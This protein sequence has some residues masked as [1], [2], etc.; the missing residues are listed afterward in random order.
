MDDVASSG[1]ETLDELLGGLFWGDN[2]VWEVAGA[3]AGDAFYASA[4][5]VAGYD[6]RIAIRLTTPSGR[7]RASR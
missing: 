2:V 6:G 7:P 5:A 4:A 1:V 3:A